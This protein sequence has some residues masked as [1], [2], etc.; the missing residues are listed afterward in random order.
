MIA[1]YT[2]H[3]LRHIALH[4]LPGGRRAALV[5][6]WAWLTDMARQRRLGAALKGYAA[7]L[8]HWLSWRLDRRTRRSVPTLEVRDA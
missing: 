4:G 5:Q 7:A 2:K 1:L 6:E 3:R 8:P